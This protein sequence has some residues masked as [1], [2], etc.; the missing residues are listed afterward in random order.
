MSFLKTLS[1]AVIA[2]AAIGATSCGCCT[3]EAN[4]PSLQPLPKF[5]DVPV[6]EH[7]PAVDDA[8]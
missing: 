4:V 2:L 3:G 1:L 7:V 5:K 6:V 8:K